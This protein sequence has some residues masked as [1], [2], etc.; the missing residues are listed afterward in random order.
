MRSRF[1]SRGFLAAFC[2]TFF[3]NGLA[4]AAKEPSRAV[5]GD[6]MPNLSFKD[7]HGKTHRLYDLKDKKAIV[8]VF[9]SFECPVSNSY[10]APLAEIAQEFG[11]HGVAVWGLTTNED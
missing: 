5:L 7:E 6:R 8:L 2:A 4:A 11:K 1:L 3:L 10:A 9:L